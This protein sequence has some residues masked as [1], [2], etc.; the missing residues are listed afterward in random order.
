MTKTQARRP[1]NSRSPKTAKPEKLNGDQAPQ[2]WDIL[3]AD[4]ALLDVD[5]KAKKAFVHLLETK[6][7]GRRI[8]VRA[9]D[10]SR[11]RRKQEIVKLLKNSVTPLDAGIYISQRFGVTRKWARTMVKKVLDGDA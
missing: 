3:L 7:S 2:D 11:E 4:I 8:Y 1:L 5:D 6:F 10:A 9:Q